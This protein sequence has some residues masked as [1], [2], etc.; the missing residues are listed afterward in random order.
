MNDHVGGT[1][2]IPQKPDF[3]FFELQ[4]KK[5]LQCK[6]LIFLDMLTEGW[7]NWM[8]SRNGMNHGTSEA[9]QTFWA[10]SRPFWLQYAL[11][12]YIKYACHSSHIFSN[13]H[14]FMSDSGCLT[15]LQPITAVS[16]KIRGFTPPNHR[17]SPAIP[18]R[19]IETSIGQLRYT[20]PHECS[21]ALS[22]GEG[23]D[24]ITELK[25][26]SNITSK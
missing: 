24:G 1:P 9:I 3:W 18:G 13:R 4:K 20:L 15:V 7:P 21:V 25:V 22:E 6:I 26:S 17:T 5:I 23:G 8:I 11:A 19:Y 16:G 2:P 12:Q 14:V 10:S